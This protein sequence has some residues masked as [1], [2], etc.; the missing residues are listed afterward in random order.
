ML[1]NELR[2][3]GVE[4]WLDIRDLK[5]GSDW[6]QSVMSAIKS[7]SGFVFLIGPPGSSDRWQTFEWQQIVAN[8]YYLDPLKPLVP[9][10]IGPPDLPGFLKTRQA[11]FL[12]DD[13]GAIKEVADKIVEAVA[14]PS[15]SVNSEKLERGRQ[16]RRK[17]LDNLKQYSQALEEEDLKRAGIR[18]VE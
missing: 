10:L 13:P 11:L 7:A 17:A 8:E 9:V 6:D 12:D 3:R 1:S 16:A 4:T 14:N 2:S 5:P 18:A 15:T